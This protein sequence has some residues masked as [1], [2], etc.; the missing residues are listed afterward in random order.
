MRLGH[1]VCGA[2]QNFWVYHCGMQQS[3]SLMDKQLLRAICK[4]E[5]VALNKK[6]RSAA[7]ALFNMPSHTKSLIGSKDC[8]NVCWAM[9][10][11]FGTS[12]LMDSPHNSRICRF[13]TKLGLEVGDCKV[14]LAL[15][16]YEPIDL[17]MLYSKR[18]SRAKST[19]PTP[20]DLRTCEL[21][22]LT[23]TPRLNNFVALEFVKR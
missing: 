15:I 16:F 23:V 22:Y 6:S 21:Q 8:W 1:Q 4:A 9:H 5:R 14:S 19:K 7:T 11:I 13:R 12:F 2:A 17:L 10:I 20:G 3:H 18:M